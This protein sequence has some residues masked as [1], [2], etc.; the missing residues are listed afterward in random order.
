VSRVRVDEAARPGQR[1]RRTGHTP[2]R[3]QERQFNLGR[4]SVGSGKEWEPMSGTYV[5]WD[6]VG[7]RVSSP[8]PEVPRLHFF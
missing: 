6:N 7:V 1:G 3:V 2:R 8:D 4:C 5:R